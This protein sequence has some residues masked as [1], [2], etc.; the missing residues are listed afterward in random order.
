MAEARIQ[1]LDDRAK[2]FLQKLIDLVD[3]SNCYMVFKR[4][5]YRQII[6]IT[7]V[8]AFQKYTEA[9]DAIALLKKIDFLLPTKIEDDLES[10]KKRL[11]E[12][13]GNIIKAQ[14]VEE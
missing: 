7:R 3:K 14:I 9:E 11:R 6:H 4:R 5:M 1:L 8:R 2:G 13:P 10:L 12:N